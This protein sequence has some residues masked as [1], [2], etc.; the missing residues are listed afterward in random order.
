MT[1]D[2]EV[3]PPF[4][5]IEPLRRRVADGDSGDVEGRLDP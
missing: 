5:R 4:L 1:F 3:L 2:A